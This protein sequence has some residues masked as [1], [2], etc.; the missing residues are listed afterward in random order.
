MSS[1]ELDERDFEAVMEV[2]KS[3]RIALGPK[4][5]QFERMMA[6]YVGV[7]HAVAVS[8]GTAGLH[9]IVKALGI[10]AG[11]EVIVPSFTF[12][13]S[14]NAILY[15][16]AT[17]VFVDIE[18]QT[19]N[20]DPNEVERKIAPRTKAVMVVD[21]FGHP[22]DWD[23]LIDIA[24]RHNLMLIDDCC[25]AIGARYKGRMLGQMGEAGAFA[26]YPNKQMT[27]GEGGMIVTNNDEIARLCR[28]LRNQGRAEMGAWLEHERMGYNY[29]IDEL[30]AALGVSQL[31]RLDT[32]LQK[33]QRVAQ[34]YTEQI[35]R[36]DWARP[37]LVL[38][39][40]AMSWFVYV[41]TLS[42]GLERDPIIARLAEMGVPAR[43][44]FAPLHRQTYIQQLGFGDTSLPITEEIA[45]RTIALPFHN[46]LPDDDI[47]YIIDCLRQAIESH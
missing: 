38:P 44:Y 22:A 40:I 32:F 41:I 24:H 28:S 31:Q 2:L 6:D 3:G 9:L 27:A 21:V 10:G 33:R 11:D 47:D 36:Y 7:K 17:P 4:T 14:V 13:A 18:P 23:A 8:S 42:K 37:P 39:G 12:A 19:Y 35:S 1:A 46:N 34:R 43:G 15:E 5:E 16:G 20:L 25:E 29:R 45:K 26:F 30:S